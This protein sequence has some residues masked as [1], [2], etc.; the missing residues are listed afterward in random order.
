MDGLCAWILQMRDKLSR[1]GRLESEFSRPNETVLGNKNSSTV[2]LTGVF[3]FFF[4][5]CMVYYFFGTD[6]DGI[7][8]ASTEFWV[9]ELHLLQNHH[10]DILLG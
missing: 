1:N 6:D 5:I 3:L 8:N 7:S 2:D 10:N 4:C 9:K